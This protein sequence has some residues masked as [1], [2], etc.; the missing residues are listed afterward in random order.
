MIIF[1]VA[2]LFLVLHNGHIAVAATRYDYGEALRLSILFYDAQ[3]SGKLPADNPIPWRHDSALQDSDGSV[4]LTGGWYD[5]GDHVKFNFPMAA[6]T[7]NLLWGLVKWTDGYQSSGQLDM[8]YD[9]IKWPLQYFLKCWLPDTSTYYVQVGDGKL[10][11]AYWG[12]AEDM[13]M[14]RPAFKVTQN[15]P[16][17]DVAGNT[18]AA[19][20]AG[21][22]A[23][24]TKDS[25]FSTKLLTAAKSL[26]KFAKDY[27][28]IYS[29][30]VPEANL[31]YSSTGYRDELCLGAAWLYKATN[32]SQY[33]TDAKSFYDP[34]TAWAESWD[35]KKVSCQLLLFELTKEAKYKNNVEAF[36]QSWMP[37]GS[38]PYTPCGLA[39]RI[40]W[41]SLRYAANTAFV[42]L[43]AADNGINSDAYKKWALSQMNYILGDNNLHISYEIGFGSKY[44]QHPHHRGSSC[45]DAPNTCTVQH[46]HSSSPNPN[47]LKGALVGGP[48]QND[49]YV[50]NRNDYVKNEVAVDYNAGFQSALAGLAHFESNGGLPEPDAPKC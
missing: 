48:G 36:M 8:M 39:F 40:K 28:G 33:L 19:F 32:D 47:V 17:S 26:Y 41:G 16:G 43:M 49:D 12:R 15:N 35:E 38:V 14:A 4:D 25:A 24:K 7:T 30:S 6:A 11:F 23:F 37:G 29:Q 5:A 31:Y 13:T 45:P 18:A 34:A 2:S 46:Q 3:R 44:P 27:K 42:A 10:D 50:D 9:M 1:L 22:I 21:S 20:A